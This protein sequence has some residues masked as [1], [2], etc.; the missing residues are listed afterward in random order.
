MSSALERVCEACHHE[1]HFERTCLR[2]YQQNL[3]LYVLRLNHG[4]LSCYRLDQW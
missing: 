3:Y 2:L 1:A 4:R